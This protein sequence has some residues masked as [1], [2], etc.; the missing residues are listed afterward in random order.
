M[1]GA[2]DDGRIEA[3]ACKRL[4][5]RQVPIDIDRMRR[6]A[7]SDNGRDFR[8]LSRIDKDQGFAAEAVEV[9]LEHA[10]RQQSCHAGIEGVAALK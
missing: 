5:A 7:L 6:P 3:V 9:L 1:D 10:T 2:G 8:F 4:M